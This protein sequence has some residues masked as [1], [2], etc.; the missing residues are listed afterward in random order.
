MTR[1]PR[2]V[3]PIGRGQARIDRGW[4][5]ALAGC[6]IAAIALGLY[7]HVHCE[8]VDLLEAL[9][10]TLVLFALEGEN[11]SGDCAKQSSIQSTIALARMLAAVTVI[12][13][14]VKL[15]LI[16]VYD[17]DLLFD[18]RRWS[19][20]IVL[21]GLGAL[22]QKLA[23]ECRPTYKVVVIEAAPSDHQI[24]FCRDHDLILLGGDATDPLV[25]DRAGVSCA[26]HLVLL[27]GDDTTNL[28]AAARAR[29]LVTETSRPGRPGPLQIH[30]HLADAPLLQ[31]LVADRR[32]M[33]PGPDGAVRMRPFNAATIAA[34]RVLARHPLYTY[35]E[36]KGQERMHAVLAGFGPQGEA[37]VVQAVLSCH[38]RD[39]ERPLFTVLDRNAETREQRLLARYPYIREACD[40]RFVQADIDLRLPEEVLAD[41]EGAAPVTVWFVCL[42]SD[43]RNV[44]A[45][46]MLHQGTQQ[47]RRC[48]APVFFHVHGKEGLAGALS[49][50]APTKDLSRWLVP[51]GLLGEGCK[52]DIL[53][54][55]L[56][57]LAIRIHEAYLRAEDAKIRAAGGESAVRAWR[58]G[59]NAQPWTGDLP[60][61]YR[62]SNRRAA[63]HLRVKLASVGCVVHDD[64]TLVAPGLG[65]ADRPEERE[66]LARIEHKRWSAD[67]LIDGWRPGPTRDNERKVH[68]LLVPYEALTPEDQAKDAQQVLD[69]CRL[70]RED[71]ALGSVR[72]DLWVALVAEPCRDPQRF[73][74]VREALAREVLSLLLD[75]YPYHHLTL[76]SRLTSWAEC[77]VVESAS[78]FL[79][80]AARPHRLLVTRSL[81]FSLYSFNGG[82]AQV[83]PDQGVARRSLEKTLERCELVI[84]LVPSGI[85]ETDI[86]RHP[87]LQGDL[88]Q[89][90][91]A[92]LAERSD[93]LVAVYDAEGDGPG[94]EAVDIVTW[95]Q[96]RSK[97]P[98]ALSSLS[99]RQ[100]TTRPAR[101]AWIHVDPAARRIGHHL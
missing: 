36:L 47:S 53:D 37:L 93:V 42:G 12:A 8:G 15:V 55:D 7:S 26:A 23:K 13:A 30:L 70:F 84:D 86:N 25:L 14:L 90:A 50:T 91:G 78:A 60:E 96:D 27:C 34:R 101:T 57:R 2:R 68:H 85:F 24:L 19:G 81:P 44:Q 77:Q 64:P 35:A 32:F 9:Y 66:A 28:E 20:H 51:F 54:E 99:D 31:Q 61:T 18:V 75:R 62:E 59:E 83:D 95:R 98:R 38:Y 63:D 65:F 40:L 76:L 16:G 97:V 52:Q 72:R 49:T 71:D 41:I 73:G 33:R 43:Q 69:L 29:S 89:R 17:R 39:F 4:W 94:V 21:C 80:A 100:L 22:G 87:L 46:L 56:D 67:R 92:Y 5:V 1:E 10:R 79:R 82:P 45:A 58:Q 3:V 6:G 11:V 74:W 88:G 48:L